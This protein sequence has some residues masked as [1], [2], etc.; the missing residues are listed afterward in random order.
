MKTNKILNLISKLNDE[1][2]YY[3]KEFNDKINSKIV[4]IITDLN[5][6][7]LF[8]LYV[9]M[10]ILFNKATLDY[11]ASDIKTE[12]TLNTYKKCVKEIDKEIKKRLYNISYESLDEA[13]SVVNEFLNNTKYPNIDKNINYKYIIYKGLLEQI[14]TSKIYVK[15]TDL[16]KFEFKELI[17][18]NLKYTFNIDEAL[19]NRIV[20]SL[21]RK[22]YSEEDINHIK[23]LINKYT[24]KASSIDERFKYDNLETDDFKVYLNMNNTKELYLK[25]IEFLSNILKKLNKQA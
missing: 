24:K 8:S 14:N 20:S 11:K 12:V 19:E 17:H 4:D 10:L 16:D 2:N 7:E 13:I 23:Y 18:F 21:S 15:L 3:N 22:K 6:N 5:F 25:R 9:E 1:G